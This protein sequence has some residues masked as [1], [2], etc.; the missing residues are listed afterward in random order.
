MT[1]QSC[2]PLI[3]YPTALTTCGV[4]AGCKRPPESN[5]HVVCV[6]RSSNF[7]NNRDNVLP[8]VI[9]IK[10]L[11]QD[12]LLYVPLNVDNRKSHLY[13]ICSVLTIENTHTHSRTH[14]PHARLSFSIPLFSF[15]KTLR[16]LPQAYM[17]MQYVVD[18]N[19]TA[20]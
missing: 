13:F 19:Q 17:F 20:C 9:K 2:P 5:N 18:L 7:Q 10:T 16:E 12:S 3:N 11:Q 14:T 8:G 1:F 4:R 15:N 6:S